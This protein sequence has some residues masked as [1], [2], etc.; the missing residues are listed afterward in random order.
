M[1]LKPALDG[2]RLV[3]RGVVEH[4]QLPLVVSYGR[5]TSRTYPARGRR[6]LP[7]IPGNPRNARVERPCSQLEYPPIP[8]QP[9]GAKTGLSRRRSRVRVPS[10]PSF[11]HRFSG[12]LVLAEEEWRERLLRPHRDDAAVVEPDALEDQVEQ[13]A[14]GV[15]GLPRCARRRRSRRAHGPPVR[16]SE[17][18]AVQVPRAFPAAPRA[19]RCTPAC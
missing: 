7:P 13:L 18:V 16:C 8:A 3:R 15:W 5:G 10:L 4:H 17:L 12:G 2:R 9:G 6:K 19:A 1:A 14:S 11:K